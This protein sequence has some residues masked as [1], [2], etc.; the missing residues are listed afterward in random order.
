[1]RNN[2]N[3]T[4]AFYCSDRSNIALKPPSGI[5]VHQLL[6]CLWAQVQVAHFCFNCANFNLI[7]IDVKLEMNKNRSLLNIRYVLQFQLNNV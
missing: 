6:M 7:A 4:T 3:R 5:Y 1:M 2:H